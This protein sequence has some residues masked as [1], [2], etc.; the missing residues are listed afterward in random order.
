MTTFFTSDPHFGHAN[1]IKFCNRP[2]SSVEEMDEAMIE[3]WNGKIKDGD[4]VYLVGD[5]S[6]H[7]PAKTQEII[8]RL[9]GHKHLI[10]GNHDR[11]LKPNILECFD[12]VNQMLDIS[13][14]DHELPR[15]KQDIVLCHYA[16]RV[17]NASHYGSWQLYGHSHG[18]LA[19][20]PHRLAIDVG[21]DCHNFTPLSYHDIKEIMSRKTPR[22][23]HEYRD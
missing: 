1:I 14:S 13:V 20:E 15:G 7:K 23:E 6:F 18:G 3:R 12:S 21:V 22:K 9:N 10:L 5:F 17:W 11:H 16:M 8:D 4:T 2:F 19:D